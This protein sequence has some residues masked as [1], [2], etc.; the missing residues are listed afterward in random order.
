MLQEYYILCRK[1]GVISVWLLKPKR[2][3]QFPLEEVQKVYYD[4]L[5]MPINSNHTQ[6]QNCWRLSH[7]NSDERGVIWALHALINSNNNL[8]KWHPCVQLQQTAT[9]N[10]TSIKNVMQYPKWH[11]S[12]SSGETSWRPLCVAGRN[13]SKWQ[14]FSTQTVFT[15]FVTEYSY[16][17]ITIK[18]FGPNAKS[19]L[20]LAQ[21]ADSSSSQVFLI[22]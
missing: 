7:Y 4:A 2:C 10:C 6:V 20:L 5:I 11:V 12:N 8:A 1:I 14:Y 16:V 3:P 21:K 17:S 13:A 18:K 19:Y 9:Y 22:K 15:P